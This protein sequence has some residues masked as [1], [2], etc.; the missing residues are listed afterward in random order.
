[1]S[2]SEWSGSVLENQQLLELEKAYEIIAAYLGRDND[3]TEVDFSNMRDTP[4]RVAKSFMEMTQTRTQISQKIKDIISTAFPS[5]KSSGHL[6]GI[7]TQGPIEV[8]SLCPHHWLPVKY[9]I[10]VSY[11]PS[12]EGNVLGLSKLARLCI[13]LGKRPVLQ[14][15]LT[16]DI[17]D[18]LHWEESATHE[19]QWPSINSAGSASRVIGKH[20]CFDG[21]TEILTEHGWTKF[22]NLED[23][24]RVAQVDV[25]NGM[26]TSLVKPLRVIRQKN[27]FDHLLHFKNRCVDLMVTPDHNVINTTAWKYNHNNGYFTWNF[28]PAN[29]LPVEF[30]V[31]KQIEWDERTAIKDVKIDGHKIE[32][33]K[34]I[35]LLGLY[36]SEGCWRGTGSWLHNMRNKIGIEIVQKKGTPECNKIIKFLKTLPFRIDREL[37]NGAYHFIIHSIDLPNYLIKFGRLCVDMCLPRSLLNAPI[38]QQKLFLEWFYLGDG[39][40]W[41]FKPEN[42]EKFE[43]SRGQIISTASKKL[44]R[45]LQELYFKCGMDT[46]IHTY[47]DADYQQGGNKYRIWQQLGKGQNNV[48]DGKQAA[49]F[50][51]SS[52][53]PE[54]IPHTGM[55]YCVTVPTSAIVIRRSGLITVVG[56]C[57]SCRG[58][59]SNALTV[60]AEVRG[61]FREEHME[62]KFDVFCDDARKFRSH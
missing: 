34:F 38:D 15:D 40:K 37:Q 7:I 35:K 49:F 61:K 14:E 2:K 52:T 9:E 36:F 18:V 20:S 27:N 32:A 58:V 16:K 8:V 29:Q 13:E 51:T 50:R 17:A 59:M 31:P 11:I 53:P 57:M 47:E 19:P 44:A 28:T 42:K 24:V 45:D 62:R 10:F 3:L 12:I 60:T 30:Y 21:N 46:H 41:H 23:G 4:R 33:E 26:K 25:N 39:D 43:R 55:V 1:M 48:E 54:I 5:S 56:N 6:P 22:K